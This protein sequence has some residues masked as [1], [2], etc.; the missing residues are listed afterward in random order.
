MFEPLF[1]RVY[2]SDVNTAIEVTEKN[3]IRKLNRRYKFPEGVPYIEGELYL[4]KYFKREYDYDLHK[5]FLQGKENEYVRSL[6]TNGIIKSLPAIIRMRHL[7]DYVLSTDFVY[8]RRFFIFSSR[9][10]KILLEASSNLI[11]CPIR[12]HLFDNYHTPEVHEWSKEYTD[13]FSIVF[14][15]DATKILSPSVAQI[16]DEELW[17][18]MSGLENRLP[19]CKIEDVLP[20][21]AC[22]QII[23]T[24]CVDT[25]LR[26]ALQ[27]AKMRGVFFDITYQNFPFTHHHVPVQQ[28]FETEEDEIARVLLVQG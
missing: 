6:A 27:A 18:V 20:I 3:T 5:D 26:R 8:S 2:C 7:K 12:I 1:F 28:A 14:V 19:E 10:V 21:F 9:I 24:L 16:A 13:D 22:S 4:D 23:S 25:N 17:K 11:I 15:P